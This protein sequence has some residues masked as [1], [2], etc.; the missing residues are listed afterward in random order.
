VEGG[1]REIGQFLGRKG[2]KWDE[3]HVL[4][5]SIIEGTRSRSKKKSI[6]TGCF[7]GAT[8]RGKKGERGLKKHRTAGEGGG[9]KLRNQV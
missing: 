6:T 8:I 1:K 3:R 9:N 5:E 4:K 2:T 7:N